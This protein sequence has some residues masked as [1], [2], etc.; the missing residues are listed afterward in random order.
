MPRGSTFA[1]RGSIAA[2]CLAR[3][4]KPHWHEC[5]LV[6][7]VECALVETQPV[8][9]SV[10][11]VVIPRDAA[12]VDFGARSLADDQYARSGGKLDHRA[13]TQGQML[14]ADGAVLDLGVK[15]RRVTGPAHPSTRSASSSQRSSAASFS[16]RAFSKPLEILANRLGSLVKRSG[17]ARM[18]SPL[19]IAA[20]SSSIRAGSSS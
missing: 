6:G 11:A 13:W 16:L 12:F 5:H 10:T 14:C 8:P 20:S 9:Q 17:S 19:A 18:L 2:F 3:I 4:A 15:S 7:I 1:A